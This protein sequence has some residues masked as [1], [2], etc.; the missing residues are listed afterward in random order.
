M[1]DNFIISFYI[2]LLASSVVYPLPGK[3]IYPSIL[4]PLSWAGVRPFLNP[5]GLSRYPYQLRV[6]R[7]VVH[8]FIFFLS[9]L[10]LFLNQK[11]AAQCAHFVRFF[12]L[13]VLGMG[14]FLTPR[15]KQSFVCDKR[16]GVNQLELAP[17]PV[18]KI[19]ALRCSLPPFFLPPFVF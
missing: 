2:D 5:M 8:F 13:F 4:V 7:R 11:K 14:H 12:Y 16:F 1:G 9:N 15:A 6:D 19:F 3:K 17:L 10:F 18:L